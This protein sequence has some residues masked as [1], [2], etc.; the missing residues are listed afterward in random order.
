MKVILSYITSAVL[1]SAM[2]IQ[3]VS[4]QQKDQKRGQAGGTQLLINPWSRSAGWGGANQAGVK[5]IE[6][7]RMNVGGLAH[8]NQTDVQFV[9][10]TYLQGSDITINAIG[11]AQKVGEEGVL[12]AS[13]MFFDAGE[14]IETTYLE[15]EGTGNTFNTSI[16]NLGLSYARTFSDRVSGG[17]LVRVMSESIPTV[18]AE[19]VA[20]DAGIQYKTGAKD[21]FKFG[22]SLRNIG[23]KMKYSGEGLNTKG[24]VEA[25]ENDFAFTVGLLSQSFNMPA[26][27]NIG[28][29]YDILNSAYNRV[30]VMGNFE[31]N[32]FTNDRYQTGAE[33]AFNEMFM[34]RGGFAYY[35]NMFDDDLRT[36]VHT[37]ISAGAT[38]QVPF[39]NSGLEIFR[40]KAKEDAPL[41]GDEEEE[42][43]IEKSPFFKGV[44]IDYAYRTSNP[45][46]GTH[47]IGI[48][49]AF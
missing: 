13:L 26:Q 9:T 39:S 38:I 18:S 7:M 34:I 45:F 6:A 33:Y 11:V 36:D 4:A 12:G 32:T 25:N 17:I 20:I 29:G 24:N 27:L 47:S 14:F 28:V 10:T 31:S 8:I 5:G 43:A 48:R 35:E 2:F 1:L 16:F 23:P 42:E 21:R 44:G 22:V 19:G 41:T 30:T 49:L 40:K 3:T 15:P 46:G 37:G